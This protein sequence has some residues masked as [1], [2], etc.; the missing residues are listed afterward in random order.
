MEQNS[1]RIGPTSEAPSVTARFIQSGAGGPRSRSH[2]QTW[3][4]T[5]VEARR[6]TRGLPAALAQYSQPSEPGTDLLAQTVP[7][8]IRRQPGPESAG[9]LS[10]K[11][12]EQPKCRN[13]GYVHRASS[14][15][16]SQQTNQN[17]IPHNRRCCK[18]NVRQWQNVNPGLGRRLGT[19]RLHSL[20]A[21]SQG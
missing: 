1:G 6:R 15:A 9:R 13:R 19:W 3:T 8:H 16:N 18:R 20:W 14:I 10:P 21:A 5:P 11:T 2:R 12:P 17:P 7:A 4:Y